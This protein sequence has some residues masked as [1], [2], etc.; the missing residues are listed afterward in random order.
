MVA[1]ELEGLEKK[2]P[3]MN[4]RVDLEVE[5]GNLLALAGPSG[6][7]KSTVLRM[8]AG[9]CPPDAGTVRIGG[10]DVTGL[11]PREREVGMVFQDYA[12]F[13]H[14]DVLSNVAY[15]FSIRG[16]PRKTR[17][18]L[19]LDI[20]ESVGMRSF[21]RRSPHELSGGERQRVALARTI[22][23]RPRVVLFD[24]PLSS[25]DSALRKHLRAEIREQQKRYGL[26]AIYV[27]HD[28]EEALAMADKVAIMDNGSILQCSTPKELWSKP[29]NA[30]VAR[31]LGNGSCLPVLHFEESEENLVAITATGRF[32]LQPDAARLLQSRGSWGQSTGTA[33]IHELCI[34]F[35]RTQAQPLPSGQP[36]LSSTK[37]SNG[38]FSAICIGADFTGDAIDCVMKAG[39]TSFPLRLSPEIAPEPGDHVRF[40]VK[41]DKVQIIPVGQHES[42]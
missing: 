27:T 34:F 28:L 13:P 3:A 41:R 2:W 42:S 11:S 39:S 22:A 38:L 29:A 8:I 6:C 20:L 14:M 7:G 1:L 24:E 18:A 4:V 37:N 36:G 26:T 12:L 33:G 21:S 17:E 25:L 15:G 31:F 35:E 16:I 40:S 10:K 23:A 5:P 32:P 19:A 9:L 30:R